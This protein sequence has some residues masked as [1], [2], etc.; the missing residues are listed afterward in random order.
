MI[1][2]VAFDAY[3]T[4]YD[5][6]SVQQKCEAA[7][8][9]N[10]AAIAQTWRQK[11]LEYTW[12]LTLMGRYQPFWAITKNALGY[13]L[14]ELGLAHSPAQIEELACAYHHLTLYPE[15]K[16]ALAALRPLKRM[17]LTNGNPEMI[18]PLLKNTGIKGEL[19]GLL[20][21]H[22]VRMYKPCAPVYQQAAEAFG[23]TKE[24]ILFVSSN[25]WD[26]AGA[27]AFGFTVGWVNRT[28]KPAEALGAPPDYTARN[29][30]GLMEVVAQ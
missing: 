14:D 17:I 10:G 7:F 9:G 6:Y 8:P 12:L 4:L 2:A 13:A 25:G 20:S 24:E 29:L 16:Q 1:K 18:A 11:Q 28:G 23:A 21:A 19:D 5:V 26:V 22:T 30:L 15:V 27:K 3:G